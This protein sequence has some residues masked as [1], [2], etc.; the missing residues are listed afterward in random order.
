MA[1]CAREF[2]LSLSRGVAGIDFESVGNTFAV[3]ARSPL[4][5]RER[6]ERC[7]FKIHF[8]VPLVKNEEPRITQIPLVVVVAVIV[9]RLFFENRYIAACSR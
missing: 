9:N 6:K 7:R 8:D 4:G 1:Y 3:T 2:R 5:V